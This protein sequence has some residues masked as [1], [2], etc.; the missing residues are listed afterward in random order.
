MLLLNL[1]SILIIDEKM[2]PITRSN[3]V[4][5]IVDGLFYINDNVIDTASKFY[6]ELKAISATYG[7]EAI[8]RLITH[9]TNL[10]SSL[11]DSSKTV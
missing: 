6:N 10:M 7:E 8:E 1:L 3:D 9:V 4:L 11:N 5:E 2:P